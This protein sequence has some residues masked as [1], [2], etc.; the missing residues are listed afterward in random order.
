ML[1]KAIKQAEK[2]DEYVIRLY[3]SSGQN[4][5]A[6]TLTFPAQILSAKELNGVEDETGTAQFEGNQL[7][8]DI[9]AFGVKTFKV[10]LASAGK[11]SLNKVSTAVLSL[12]FDTKSTTYNAFRNTANFDGKGNSFAAELFPETID[13]KGIRFELAGADE[14]N[15]LKCRGQVID[16]PQGNFKIGRAHV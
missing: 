10:K 5:Q 11:A 15:A 7:K 1:I 14:P 4:K 13:F 6:A 9:N 8:I 2:S 12:P 16:L 3:E